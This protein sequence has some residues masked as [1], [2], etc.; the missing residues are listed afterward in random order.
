MHTG[1]K[2]TSKRFVVVVH[3]N[4]SCYSPRKTHCRSEPWLKKLPLFLSTF[5]AENSTLFLQSLSRAR[6]FRNVVHLP[7]KSAEIIPS[8]TTLAA[9]SLAL[10]GS[11]SLY[12]SLALS[13]SL[14]A[15]PVAS[16][17][18]GPGRVWGGGGEREAASMM[19]GYLGD[20]DSQHLVRPEH[21]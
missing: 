3:D 19:L 4:T 10:S 11:L 7:P 15:H 1:G 13:L 2:N 14:S 9:F 17:C 5:P 16:G 20:Q 8:V 21:T 6:K 18:N 12:L